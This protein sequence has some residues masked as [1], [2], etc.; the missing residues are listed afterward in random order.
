MENGSDQEKYV[1]HRIE[2]ISHLDSFKC[3]PD[4]TIISGG[5]YFPNVTLE[6]RSKRGC[7]LDSTLEFY[8]LE[9]K[10]PYPNFDL[11]I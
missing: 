9:Q 4:I 5:I 11:K 3:S 10:K 7:G 2:H 1:L 8:G 6:I